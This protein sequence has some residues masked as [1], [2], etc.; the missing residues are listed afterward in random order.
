[1]ELSD[2][3]SD[4]G[5]NSDSEIPSISAND[6]EEDPPP[7][8]LRNFEPQP[9]SASSSVSSSSA[10]SVPS[11]K[12]RTT[13]SLKQDANVAR[14]LAAAKKKLPTRPPK[15]VY[16]TPEASSQKK[17]ET[18]KLTTVAMNEKSSTC[19][20]HFKKFDSKAHPNLSESACCNLCYK[21]AEIDPLIDFVVS[22]QV[23]QKIDTGSLNHDVV[24]EKVQVTNSSLQRFLG[25]KYD[26]T[27][28][29]SAKMS[30]RHRA[31]REKHS[32]GFSNCQ[33]W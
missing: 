10:S 17:P 22:Y 5:T 15:R 26:E 28:A 16:Q 7:L 32:S 1:M 9:S 11:K 19:W 21:E 12:S 8:P 24:L 2:D 29:T 20:K 18:F 13:T 14:N 6:R 23:G 3:Y 25:P 31:Y 30:S 33:W 4:Y 27:C